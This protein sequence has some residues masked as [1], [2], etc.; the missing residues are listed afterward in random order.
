MACGSCWNPSVF[1]KLVQDVVDS[2]AAGMLVKRRLA[3]QMGWIAE[4]PVLDIFHL[5]E[6]LNLPFS[7]SVSQF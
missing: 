6:A 2:A 3:V 1:G 4:M 7:S 5:I